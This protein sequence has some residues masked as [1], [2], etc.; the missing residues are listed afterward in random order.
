MAGLLFSLLLMQPIIKSALQS[1]W[2]GSLLLRLG[3][4]GRDRG[5][6]R[7]PQGPLPPSTTSSRAPGAATTTQPALDSLLQGEGIPGRPHPSASLST[8]PVRGARPRSWLR[9]STGGGA[10]A[11]CS[12]G[13]PAHRNRRRAHTGC[14]AP[15]LRPPAP[16]GAGARCPKLRA[17]SAAVPL[18]GESE[19]LIPTQHGGGVRGGFP[20]RRRLRGREEGAPLHAESRPTAPLPALRTLRPPTRLLRE[21][22]LGAR[23]LPPLLFTLPFDPLSVVPRAL[24]L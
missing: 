21:M 7:G 17:S 2:H 11:T 10:A 23:I 19:S 24:G 15:A 20:R 6:R 22:E 9:P 18:G 12:R 14:G 8:S 4:A 13:R 16:S 3:V 5:G 1:R